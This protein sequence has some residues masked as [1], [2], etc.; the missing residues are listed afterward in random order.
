MKKIIFTFAVAIALL[1]SCGKEAAQPEGVKTAGNNG[2]L[3]ELSFTASS[4]AMTKTAFSDGRNVAFKPGE[5]ISI[6]A[7]GTNYKFTT[8][9]GGTSAVFTGT[10]VVADKYY[11]LFPY[12]STATIDG[13]VIKGV[14]LNKSSAGTATGTYNSQKAIAVAVSDN[15]TLN[16]KQ[17]C[18]LL[19]FTVPAE[20][21]DLKEFVVFNRASAITGSLSGTFN[22]T[23]NDGAAPTVEVTA[24]EG[25]PH[26]CGASA[27][28]D[29]FAAG[30]YYIPVLPAS[31]TQ[32]ID[33]KLTFT[34]LTGRA[35]NSKAVN[36]ESGKV[37]SLGTVARTDRFVYNSFENNDFQNE[38]TGNSIGGKSVLSIVANPYKTAANSSEYVMVN[39]MSTDTWAN[40]GYYQTDIKASKFPQAVR[41]KFKK[42][43][44]EMYW[45][46]DKIYPRLLFNKGGTAKLPA[47]LNG[48]TITDQASWDAAVKTSDWNVLEWD[49]SQFD[50]KS[51][52][53]TLSS[54]QVRCW[55][56]WSNGT[57]SRD[58]ENYMHHIAWIDNVTF[59]Q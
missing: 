23:P 19:K 39:D 7:N 21:T 36:L 48:T 12:S 52:F 53:S 37:Y 11:A 43:S 28:G 26:Q 55:V 6:F 33:I 25:D 40:S 15:T 14:S 47:R 24:A 30:D 42:I 8:E 50:G 31:I 5:E 1:A 45:G 2:Q 35:F 59:I 32:G 44:V 9:E 56:N 41:D 3:V 58:D 38:Y 51:N 18:A 16:F 34:G 54:F 22:V 17:V 10:A 29:A 46:A 13:G 4:E 57:T 20:V 27:D 49:A